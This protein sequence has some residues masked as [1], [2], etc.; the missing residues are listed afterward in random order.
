MV[1]RRVA[2]SDQE[3]A[4]LL[5][6]P[7][8]RNIKEIER[9]F[10]VQVF[11]RPSDRINEGGVTLAVRG[12]PKPVEQAIAT[13]GEMKRSTVLS[14]RKNPGAVSVEVPVPGLP[15]ATSSPDAVLMSVTGQ[16]IRPRSPTQKN[17]VKAIQE[18]EMVF[19]IGPAGTGKTFLAVACAVAALE[20]GVVSRIVL[21][22]PVVEAGEKLG[23]LPG[24]FYEKVHPYLK[25]LYDAF[26]S[27]VGAERFRTMR[28]EEVIEIVP[29]AYMRGRT[30]DEAFAILDEAQNT[31]PEQMKMFLTRM[32]N[33][34][35][36]VITGDVT[37]IDLETKNRSGLVLIQEVLRGV[38]EIGFIRFT[39]IDVVRHPLVQRVL[40]A[41]DVWGERRKDA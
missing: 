32:G 28:E 10:G 27:M 6:G 16:A 15:R 11:V 2:L 17:Y 21:T 39:E 19:G 36:M 35:R 9:R 26:H 38:N 14:R 31:T 5:F 8:D 3:E 24:D 22:R 37:Q 1:T 23:F 33:G 12:K 34:S 30:L 29:L 4:V 13:L 41:Y 20:R 40:Q 7:H 18:K 25:P